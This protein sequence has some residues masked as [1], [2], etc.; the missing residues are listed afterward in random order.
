MAKPLWVHTPVTRKSGPQSPSPGSQFSRAP[1]GSLQGNAPRCGFICGECRGSPLPPHRT[2]HLPEAP[3]TQL[4]FLPCQGS[5]RLIGTGRPGT[6][7]RSRPPCQV[8]VPTGFPAGS[9]RT[10]CRAPW[11]PLSRQEQ[12]HVRARHRA[13]GPP[14][15]QASGPPGHRRLRAGL[16]TTLRP[17]PETGGNAVPKLACREPD[18]IRDFFNSNLQSWKVSPKTP[19]VASRDP[20]RDPRR[21][22]SQRQPQ[23]KKS[24]PLASQRGSLVQVKVINGWKVAGST[25]EGTP[26]FAGEDIRHQEM[27]GQWHIGGQRG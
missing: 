6:S 1:P 10:G 17:E 27:G 23:R 13:S 16:F 25:S 15:L 14:G 24:P 26:L 5:P 21:D 4:L 22:L 9:P 11:Q 20:R 3:L 12:K 2:A 19:A 8:A 18:K 7:G